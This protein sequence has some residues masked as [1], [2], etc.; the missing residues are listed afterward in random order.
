[1]ENGAKSKYDEVKREKRKAEFFITGVF[2]V[3]Q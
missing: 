1:M 3:D 2:A